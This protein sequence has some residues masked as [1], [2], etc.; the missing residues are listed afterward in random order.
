MVDP[1]FIL[2]E[3]IFDY[4]FLFA[5]SNRS[6]IYHSFNIKNHIASED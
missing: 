1:T 3:V 4:L 2:S 5:S 6:L